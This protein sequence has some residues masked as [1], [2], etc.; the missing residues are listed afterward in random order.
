MMNEARQAMLLQRVQGNP[1][2]MSAREALFIATRGGAAVLGRHDIGQI[3]PGFAADFAIFD[4]NV[5]DF[6][7]TQTDPL[8]ALVFCGPVKPRDVMINGKFVVRDGHLATMPLATLL[9]C[10]DKAASGL[11]R[12]A[13]HLA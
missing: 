4:K 12:R 2:A 6:A 9:E 8:A 10:H 1:G 11:L 13:G 3:A 7:G 5:I